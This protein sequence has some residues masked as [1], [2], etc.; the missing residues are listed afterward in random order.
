MLSKY[1]LNAAELDALN[2]LARLKRLEEQ[3]HSLCMGEAD[4]H[5]AAHEN[6]DYFAGEVR[7]V[8]NLIRNIQLELE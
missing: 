7:H 3:A 1:E 6:W 4:E 5:S 2:L 8:E